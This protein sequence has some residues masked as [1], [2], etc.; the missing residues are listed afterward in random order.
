MNSPDPYEDYESS[1]SED[2][3][4]PRE[5][6][7]R[8]VG[9]DRAE[10][11]QSDRRSE[12]AREE[13]P[14]EHAAAGPPPRDAEPGR[15]FLDNAALEEPGTTLVPAPTDRDASK[16]ATS[17]FRQGACFA[18]KYARNKS[19][20]FTEAGNWNNDDVRD[21]YGDMMRLI[22]ARAFSRPARVAR[23]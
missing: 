16:H 5:K 6:R 3:A 17:R 2:V 12:G 8:L 15:E 9:G 21:A 23:D 22:Q 7:P 19:D 4:R 20:T 10:R 18:C 14:R 1:D 11:A 13:E